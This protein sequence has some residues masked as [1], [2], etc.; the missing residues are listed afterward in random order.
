MSARELRRVAVLGRVKAGTLS[1]QS[2][3]TLLGVSYRQA[4]RLW[5]RYR[6]GGGQALKHGNAGRR[7]NRARPTR[8]RQ[9]VLKLVRTKYGGA[10]GQRFGPTLAAEHLA[11]DDGVPVHRETLRR[12][13]L[14]AGLWQR[15]RKRT[16]HRRRRERMAHA[17]ELVQLDGS[18][19][20]WFERRA[21]AACLLTLVDDATSVTLGAFGPHETIWH[22]VAVLRRWIERCGVP[23]ALYTDWKNVYVRKPNAEERATGAAPLT[24]FGRMCEALGIQ[25]IAASSPQAKGRIERNHGTHQDRLVKKLR[26]RGIS[27]L[28]AANAFL[29]TQ[30][31]AEHNARFT[32][33]PASAEDFHLPVPRGLSLDQVFRL[34]E[35]RTVGNDWV[36]R[37]HT[38]Y[39]QLERLR[40]GAP[41]RGTVEIF[42]AADG[43]L[44]I[45][46]RGRSIP[47]REISAPGGAPAAA[48]RV[49]SSAAAVPVAVEARRMTP[50]RPTATHPWRR[51][52]LENA[53]PI[54]RAMDQ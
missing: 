37:Y 20:A 13:M 11:S 33:R 44:D 52:F 46:Y 30:Y 3:A 29:D 38:R 40:E 4:K 32:V 5:R 14:A 6:T 35:T 19:H 1:L 43:T 48:P 12:W 15:A 28:M 51:P 50:A 21:P 24:Q 16:P 31:W 22:A 9:R 54:W 45:Q 26:L 23:R 34:R 47:W 39:F 36:V 41:A 53:R 49:P 18:F 7:S 25:I 42:E 8:E 17:G 27:D 10:A 2:A